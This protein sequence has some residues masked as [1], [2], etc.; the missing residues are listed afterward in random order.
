MYYAVM[1]LCSVIVLSNSSTVDMQVCRYRNRRT[2]QNCHQQLKKQL[3]LDKCAISQF[4]LNNRFTVV[5]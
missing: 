4:L 5:Q 3:T 2:G 1:Q